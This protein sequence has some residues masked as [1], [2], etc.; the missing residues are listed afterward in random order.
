MQKKRIPYAALGV[1]F[2][3]AAGIFMALITGQSW[4]YGLAGVGLVLGA[5]IDMY[6]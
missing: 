3:G 6:R 1:I 5:G 2:G 4:W